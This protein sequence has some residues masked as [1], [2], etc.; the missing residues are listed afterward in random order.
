MILKKKF[1]EKWKS[2]QFS[3]NLEWKL[4]IRADYHDR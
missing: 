4:E 2:L 1:F 3:R